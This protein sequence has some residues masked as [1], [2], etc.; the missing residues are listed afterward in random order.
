M[1]D[2]SATI[3]RDRRR[4]AACECS[5]SPPRDEPRSRFRWRS[6]PWNSFAVTFAAAPGQLVAIAGGALAI[7]RRRSLRCPRSCESP[8]A[9]HDC[10]RNRHQAS[11]AGSHRDR[12]SR[13]L[14]DADPM[15]RL[16]V[17]DAANA[18]RRR[19]RQVASFR[20]RR[21]RIFARRLPATV[22]ATIAVRGDDRHRVRRLNARRM[23]RTGPPDGCGAVRTDGQTA[24]ECTGLSKA[25]RP[26]PLRPIR[27]VANARCPRG[28]AG[29]PRER[30]TT[31]TLER[32]TLAR[33]GS[34]PRPVDAARST[35]ARDAGAAGGSA[36]CRH[37]AP[38]DSPNGRRPPPAASAATNSRR[39]RP[40]HAAEREQPRRPPP[41][42]ETSIASPP[43]ARRAAVAQERVPARLRTYVRRYFVAI[44][45]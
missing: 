43:T 1:N 14:D 28:H 11:A 39:V 3:R 33:S 25:R 37:A 22:A 32:Q 19:C 44:H 23:V 2:P 6:S 16:V 31:T 34:A 30:R 35:P 27:L 45:P 8:S 9:A 4:G 20:S 36:R 26:R 17:R 7:W 38:P 13:L 42:T 10:G 5:W 29:R 18:A 41:R 40:N 12:A 21:R 24:I 15:A